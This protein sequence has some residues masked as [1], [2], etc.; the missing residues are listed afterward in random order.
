MIAYTALQ[1]FNEGEVGSHDYLKLNASPK[2]PLG[3]L[4]IAG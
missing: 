1:Y 4:K 2:S 3:M